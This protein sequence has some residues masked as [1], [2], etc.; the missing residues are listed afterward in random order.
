MPRSKDRASGRRSTKNGRNSRLKNKLDKRGFD[1]YAVLGF[2]VT[3]A[4]DRAKITD[5]QIAK[6]YNKK[7]RRLHPDKNRDKSPEELKQLNAM[8]RLVHTAGE[9]LKDKAR[10]KAYDLE[11]SVRESSGHASQRSKFE[12]FMELQE[13][14]VTD[15][16][17][18][19]AKLEFDRGVAELNKK[20][21]VSKYSTASMSKEDTSRRLEDLMQQRDEEEIEAR[22]KR[23]FAENQK[24]DRM[25]FMKAFEKDKI[26]RA[27]KKGRDVNKLVP[28]DDIGAFNGA[29]AGFGINDDYGALYDESKFEGN[30][31]F[32][33]LGSDDESGDD[34]DSISVGSDEIDERYFHDGPMDNSDV[35]SALD[36]LMEAREAEDEMYEDIE[37]DG[38]KSAMHDKFGV[39]S[40]MGFMV[41]DRLKGIQSRRKSMKH[42]GNDDIDAYKK[43]I[44]YDDDSDDS[45]DIDS[46]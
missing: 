8:Y 5:K 16:A 7:L 23:L 38:R 4:K 43:L 13:S 25:A 19:M 18:N 44:G 11:N 22:P 46:K 12:E 30:T 9:V 2:N 37:Y 41:G 40:S 10:R 21:G 39:S 17:K 34:S 14:E 32:G 15:E 28:Y 33:G 6:A 31:K 24:F 45:Y 3:S 26:K 27:K 36:K 20:H 35:N 1:H 29:G 42:I